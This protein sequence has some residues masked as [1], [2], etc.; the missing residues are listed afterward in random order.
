MTVMYGNTGSPGMATLAHTKRPTAR[1][2]ALVFVAHTSHV[3]S[4]LADAH[5]DAVWVCSDWLHWQQM[6]AA[7]RPSVLFEEALT[8]WDANVEEMAEEF[9]L[10]VN[11]PAF[12]NGKDVTLYRGVSLG[13]VALRPAILFRAAALRIEH[14]TREL[15]REFQP[16]RIIYVDCRAETVGLTV[17]Q[18]FKVVAMVC[19][20]LDVECIDN[21]PDQTVPVEDLPMLPEAN[22]KNPDSASTPS[23]R[24]ALVRSAEIMF[25]MAS[26]LR[27]VA[28]RRR[29]RALI[30]I[31]TSMTRPL[32]NGFQRQKPEVAPIL[33]FRAQPKKLGTLLRALAAGAMFIAQPKPRALAAADRRIV[34]DILA[35]LRSNLENLAGPA[36]TVIADAMLEFLGNGERLYR[37]A[38]EIDAAERLLRRLKPVVVVIDTPKNPPNIFYAELAA[39][40]GIAVDYIWHSPML[41]E[42]F[43]TQFLG[44]DPRRAATATRSLSWGNANDRWL[45]VVAPGLNKHFV[46][47]PVAGN[48]IGYKPNA[49]T[50]D[51]KRALIL[52]YSIVSRW[53]SSLNATKY[54]YFVD[55]VNILRELGFDEIAVKLH[56]GRPSQRYYERIRDHFNL[57]CRVLKSERLHDV[58]KDYD[59]VIGP[60]HSGATFE[61]M[62]ASKE[63]Y[64]FW[65]GDDATLRKFYPDY[66]LLRSV[67]DLPDA[68]PHKRCIDNDKIL[69]DVYGGV[70]A[71]EA[72]RLFW[73][74]VAA[75][76]KGSE[77]RK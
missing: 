39:Q 7:G 64:A 42:T 57:D 72:T 26:R 24:N 21:R 38:A 73:S 19:R 71:D 28:S 18:R 6:I 8:R 74:A 66:G 9:M 48:Y 77:I 53:L 65:C 70:D 52:E 46:G 22:L 10:R 44:G 32:I 67:F 51:R 68:I 63:V 20:E 34:D 1:G 5:A 41:P 13:Q 43:G 17:D 49:G 40:L 4:E 35:R 36:N 76:A 61:A 54:E 62:A 14:A 59:L 50:A 56:P 27:A 31:N 30:T 33:F 16:R 3:T 75:P 58:L 2:G 55:A 23:L 60:I 29:P 25:H 45:D 69:R 12:S 15:I 11:D 47:S 37:W